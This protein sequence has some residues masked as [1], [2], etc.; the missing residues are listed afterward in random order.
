[1]INFYSVYLMSGT[2]YFLIANTC[3]HP[4]EIVKICHYICYNLNFICIYISHIKKWHPLLIEGRWNVG[5]SVKLIQNFALFIFCNLCRCSLMMGFHSNDQAVSQHFWKYRLAPLFVAIILVSK[6]RFFHSRLYHCH[7]S[8]YLPCE[9]SPSHP[10]GPTP[11]QLS[12]ARALQS[13]FLRSILMS[14]HLHLGLPTGLFASSFPT[15]NLCL[16]LLYFP[17]AL[18]IS[19]TA[20]STWLNRPKSTWWALRARDY[21][22]KSETLASFSIVPLHPLP[23]AQIPFGGICRKFNPLPLARKC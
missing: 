6:I 5:S 20:H 19:F 8:S 4:F 14:S 22:G 18:A 1:M 10:L 9:N 15:K 3:N 13:V 16:Y 11:G 7:F 17:H 21:K 12:P 23:E 2:Y